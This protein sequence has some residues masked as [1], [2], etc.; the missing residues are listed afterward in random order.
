M[1]DIELRVQIE[2]SERALVLDPRGANCN[3]ERR[4]EFRRGYDVLKEPEEGREYCRWLLMSRAITVP[5]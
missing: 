3:D 1:G 2:R 5:L 4:G